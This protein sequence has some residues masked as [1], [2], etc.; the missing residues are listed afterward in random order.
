MGHLARYPH[1]PT[2]KF[3][4]RN[5]HTSKEIKLS[6]NCLLGSRPLLTFD[7]SFDAAIQ[8][9]A[10]AGTPKHPELALLKEMLIQSFGTPRNHPK[11]KPFHDHVLSFFVSDGNIWARH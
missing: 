4:V 9:G 7:T 1:G 6:G 11:S 5:I 3:Q 2:F 8:V 10:K